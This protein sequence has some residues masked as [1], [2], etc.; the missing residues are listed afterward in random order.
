MGL[1]LKAYPGDLAVEIA[2]IVLIATS[3]IAAVALLAAR[4]LRRRPAIRDCILFWG[5]I[6]IVISPL[7]AAV[8]ARAGI[9]I[10]SLHVP[11]AL[12]AVAPVAPTSDEAQ[13]SEL[14][15]PKSADIDSNLPATSVS[16]LSPSAHDRRK[17]VAINTASDVN[18]DRSANLRLLTS[19]SAPSPFDAIPHAVRRWRMFATVVLGC[20]AIGTALALGGVATSSLRLRTIRRTFV[21]VAAESI[22][23]VLDDVRRILNVRRL[24]PIYRS[25]CVRTPCVTGLVRPVIVSPGR[26][27]SD[28][29]GAAVSRIQ[30]RDVLV[31]ECA[32]V[33]RRDCV[34][35]LLQRIAAAL[36]WPNPL[37]HVLNRQL[38]D[39]REEVCD[40]YVLP[41]TDA[42][43]YGET[44]L[45][46]A[47]QA[48]AAT[49]VRPIGAPVGILHWR[50][51]LEERIAGLVDET[52]DTGTRPARHGAVVAAVGFGVLALAACGS[53]LVFAQPQPKPAPIS[54][55]AEPP[56]SAAEPAATA[57]T[58][59]RREQIRAVREE[60]L[61]GLTSP[62]TPLAAEIQLVKGEPHTLSIPATV[63]AALGIRK[64]NTGWLA[65]AK[66]PT[67]KRRLVMPASTAFVPN[68][69]FR[70]RA[71]FITSSSSATV[72]EL[73]QVHT[74]FSDGKR[75]IAQTREIR[76]GDRV[77]KGDLLAAL[78]SL[79]VAEKKRDLIEAI[80]QRKLDD[81]ILKQ[82][83]A[84]PAGGVPEAMLLTTRRNV[85]TDLN[86]IS[87]AEIILRSWGISKADIASVRDEAERADAA[88]FLKRLRE[89]NASDFDRLARV[90]LRSPA[91][92]MI[93]ERNVSLN[94]VVVDNT[95]NLFQVVQIEPGA[96]GPG[97]QIIAHVPE[98]D[99][100]A[101]EELRHNSTGPIRW[102]VDRAGG[103]PAAG[104]IEEIG[105]SIDPNQHT[106]TVMGRVENREGT[107]RAGQ[108]V[109]ASVV[110]PVPEDVVEVPS[111]AVIN[112]GGQS[113]VFVQRDPAKSEYTL[114]RVMVTQRDGTRVFVRSKPFA[115]GE[116]IAPEEADEGLLSRKPLLP[117]ERVV[118][119]GVSAL[120]DILHNREAEPNRG[121][122]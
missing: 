51:S 107:L 4:G 92:A 46:L 14:T 88:T 48:G 16:V 8:L 60:I 18:D 64:G 71:P 58:P 95:T 47:R 11:A 93:I 109:T 25:D 15:S 121:A 101:I 105:Y 112:S 102:T 40:N 65:V 100:A 108:F 83:E 41:G 106:T 81:E 119:T 96:R 1:L 53:N 17:S 24:P 117:G 86:A 7:A 34:V 63:R 72:V 97:L 42:V 113:V 91:D 33:L 56:A 38:A 66:K 61:R 73:G 82:I 3:L 80:Y 21:P 32:H 27:L 118:A 20:W 59:E 68:S 77:A 116:E 98:D 55:N 120:L 39:A 6:W 90:E 49:G 52:R 122:K 50:G 67:R 89:H 57:E 9:A 31:H 54:T 19:S 104:F 12:L 43:S 22:G 115:K 5:L 75:M 103:P 44:L 79:E 28:G 87:R 114:R 94:E 111:D 110:L 36:L 26:Y 85:Q 76:S 30:L 84:H 23:D 62:S 69:L 78:Y 37:V 29:D 13:F 99:V 2:A 70:I 74:M 45:Q 10:V 35:V